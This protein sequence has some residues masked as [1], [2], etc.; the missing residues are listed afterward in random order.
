LSVIRNGLLSGGNRL[1]LRESQL[2][3]A[4]LVTLEPNQARAEIELPWPVATTTQALQFEL[5]VLSGGHNAAESQLS[6]TSSLD[7]LNQLSQQ[8]LPDPITGWTP[9]VDGNGR[10]EHQLE[11][12]LLLRFAFGTFPGKSL[13]VGLPWPAS[14]ASSAGNQ[15]QVDDRAA[16]A[17]Q[18]I[19]TGLSGGLPEPDLRT[20][21]QLLHV[22]GS[23][24]YPFG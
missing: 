1:L 19:S 22:D 9:D 7:D 18:W 4:E 20:F 3:L 17:S 5:D 12:Q 11:G 6:L 13:T 2:G 14:S 24:P 10:F 23:S 8:L 21:M 15:L 16:E